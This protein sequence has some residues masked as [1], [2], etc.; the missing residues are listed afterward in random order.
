MP[1]FDF[2][3]S[4]PRLYLSYCNP[5]N[6]TH[7]A[8]MVELLH[9]GPSMKWHPTARDFIPD[10]EAASKAFAMHHQKLLDQGIGRYLVSLKPLNSNG[11]ELGANSVPFSERELTPIGCVSMQVAR[12]EGVAAPSIPDVGFNMHEKYHGKG[13]AT[14]AVRGLL[15]YFTEEKGIST[16]SGLTNENNEDARRLFRRL[17]FTEHG[18]RTVEG[19]MWTGK[20]AD[21]DV[22][23]FGIPE[24]KTLEDYRL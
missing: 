23:T 20:A 11:E 24:G 7:C 2:H 6:A 15:N 5:D 13:Y 17:G 19:I 21:L 1:D 3:I 8:F 16:F 9:G 18:V 10:A 22:W 12:L 4:T 14:E